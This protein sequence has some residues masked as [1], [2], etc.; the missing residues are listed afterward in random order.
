[1]EHGRSAAAAALHMAA[2][3]QGSVTHE[4]DQA[5][6]VRGQVPRPGHL[7]TPG[8]L[9]SKSVSRTRRRRAGALPSH[10]PSPGG[11]DRSGD[12]LARREAPGGRELLDRILNTPRLERVV[13][14]LQPG[15]LHRVIQLCGLEDCGELVALA[16]PEQ[17]ARIFDL[18]L[19]RAAKP[20]LDE[21]F[22][23]DRFGLWLEVLLESGPAAAAQKLAGMD[24]D[25]VV[26]GLAQHVLVYD[27]A[28]VTPDETMDG[29][30]MDAIRA[31]DDG[32]TSDVGGCVLVARRADSWEAIVE[33]LISLDA[34][35]SGYFHQV[36]RGCRMLSDSKPEV[37]GLHDLLPERE[38]V[39]FDLAVERE[40]RREQQ[41][42]VLP[43]Q[44]RAFL[45][46]SR[47]LR[48]TSDAMPAANPLARAYFRA[49]DEGMGADLHSASGLLAAGS[50]A[51]PAAEETA[52]AV[53]AVCS[54]LREAGVLAPA[55]RALLGGAEGHAPRL[56]RI[57]AHLQWV[58]DH[59]PAAYATRSEELA[60]LANT[61]MAGCSIQGQP[62]TAQEASDA[63]VA[64]CNLGLENWPSHWLPA[65]ATAPPGS[66]LVD[67]DL[68]SV[69]QVG[70][71]VLHHE[72]SLYAAEQLIGVLTRMRCDDR[73]MNAGLEALRSSLKKH[74]QAGAPWRARDA[75]DV[76]ATLDLVA[77][78]VLLALISECPVLHAGVGASRD[79]RRLS[80]SATDFEFIS[81]NSQIAAV[82]EFL[83]SL[84][85]RL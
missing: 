23:A 47:Q 80:V 51:S 75:L 74:W 78:A 48:L 15:L 11:A 22:D 12:K 35:H 72:V 54:V 39:I 65:K 32:L 38:Q 60:Y 7:N 52:E 81:E 68:V 41:G 53:E 2:P 9:M 76:M 73:E 84:P 17:L 77:W 20:G 58:L 64:V 49:I 83:Q 45:H 56:G 50:E 26:A 40:G 13:P 82:R 67:H 85:E 55:Q 24:L 66:L 79:S 1:M 69:F 57:Q 42:Y 30:Q 29:E 27:R 5:Q 71:A 3:P 18:D 37:D 16:T 46:M 63:A 21:Q 36:M 8:G 10:T 33:V 19:W 31:I 70:W 6:V 62:L 59:D 61:L 25:L 4:D 43:P 28:A 14:R 44:A 34:E